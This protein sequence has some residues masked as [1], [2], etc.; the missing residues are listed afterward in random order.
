VPPQGLQWLIILGLGITA[1]LGQYFM[2]KSLHLEKANIVAIVKYTGILY[3]LVF[4][5][6]IF[7]ETYTWQSFLGIVMILSGIAFNLLLPAKPGDGQRV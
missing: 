5:F 6:L 1:Q 2:T 3:S 4:G 7:Q